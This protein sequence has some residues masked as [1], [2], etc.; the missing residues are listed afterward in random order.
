MLCRSSLA[1]V[2]AEDGPQLEE[3]AVSSDDSGGFVAG[4]CV[5]RIS[6]RAAKGFSRQ[7]RAL[8]EELLAQRS[9]A[10]VLR[11]ASRTRLDAVTAATALCRLAKCPD[12]AAVAE[13]VRASGLFSFVHQF[14]ARGL[15]NSLWALAA[16]GLAD[17]PVLQYL[18]DSSLLRVSEFSSQGLSNTAWALAALTVFNGPLMAAIAQRAVDIS[19]GLSHQDISSIAWAYARLAYCDRPLLQALSTS[20]ATGLHGHFVPQDL[21]NTA[22]SFATLQFRDQPVLQAISRKSTQIIGEF[23]A[24]N[25]GNLAWALDALEYQEAPIF[26]CISEAA[27]EADL[28]LQSLALLVDRGHLLP[29]HHL[30]ARLLRQTASDFAELLSDLCRCREANKTAARP[31]F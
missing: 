18:V 13:E 6:L 1:G 10:A 15:A 20:A 2:T 21:A 17:A 31:R 11:T 24:Q 7:Q 23:A 12:A 27:V 4:R 29:Q 3:V 14:D 28:D 16:I 8:G 26:H 25:L 22:W 19:D 30:L 5:A 9:A